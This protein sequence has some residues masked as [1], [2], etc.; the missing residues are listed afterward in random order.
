M[1]CGFLCYSMGCNPL[2]SLFV[3]MLQLS[4]IG[5]GTVRAPSAGAVSFDVSP[6]FSEHILAFWSHKM[7]QA[8]LVLFLVSVIFPR[9]AGFFWWTMVIETKIWA[10]GVCTAVGVPL[11]L[12]LVMN[13]AGRHMC[14]YTHSHLHFF[15]SRS[16]YTKSHEYTLTPPNSP[17]GPGP[18][19]SS[20]CPSLH[21]L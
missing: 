8:H 15:L 21:S 19:R 17:G 10:P 1:A 2:L 6:W 20:C 9:S 3:L 16:I 18:D 14:V 11:T 5:I 7:L 13:R 4:T 12:G